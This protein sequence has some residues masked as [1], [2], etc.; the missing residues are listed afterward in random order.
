MRTE[1]KVIAGFALFL[2]STIARAASVV[3]LWDCR[4]ETQDR[5]LQIRAQVGE[6]IRS[7]PRSLQLVITDLS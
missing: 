4:T 3:P 6:V 1:M 5:D 2:A 7:V